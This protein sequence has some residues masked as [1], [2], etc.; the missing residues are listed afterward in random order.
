MRKTAIHIMTFVLVFSILQVYLHTES[1]EE[2]LQEAKILIFDKKWGQA[3]KKLEAILEGYP[4]SRWYSQALFFKGKCLAEQEGKEI[5]AMDVFKS[6][7]QL[8]TP[9][10]SLV[11]ESE[12]AMLDLAFRLYEK[13]KRSYLEEIEKKL[14]SRN[15]VIRYYA[16][17]KLSYVKDKKSAEKGLPVL[18]KIINQE[19][20]DE[21]KDRAK[22]AIL[23]VDPNVL[24]ELE[25][26][27]EEPRART[28]YIRVYK[29][30]VKEPT[31]KLNIPW[32]LA[33]LAFSAIPEK[34]KAV[35]RKEGY[36][37]DR[38]IQ[39]LLEF[40]GE[41]LEFRDKDTIIKIWLK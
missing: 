27:I 18:K 31:F 14:N 4:E 38:V 22:L 40:K 25:G 26:E 29:E 5:Q 34:E 6:Y 16:A 35:M 2:L 12:I 39:Q 20:D 41:I 24:R 10:Q 11:E 33:D 17:F 13:G 9:S 8:T 36:D 3:L 1:D 21:L 15:K 7:T 37:I 28:L 19:R 23:R 30:G 32:A